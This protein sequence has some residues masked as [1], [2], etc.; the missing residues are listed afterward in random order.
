MSARDAVYG[1]LANDATL[2]ALLS[3]KSELE[4][5]G[6]AIYELW[7]AP[8][9]EKPYINLSYGF[10]AAAGSNV[11]RAGTLAV[12]VFTAGNDSRIPETICNR[13]KQLLNTQILYDMQDGPVRL[14]LDNENEIPEPADNE[15]VLHW[16]LSFTVIH[17]Q[18]DNIR[19]F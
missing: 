14:Y 17:W 18:K 15:N 2:T 5:G 7:A 6:P 9:T 3:Q 10:G 4:G 16:T 8:G 12:D 13:V 1:R 11:K 19:Y